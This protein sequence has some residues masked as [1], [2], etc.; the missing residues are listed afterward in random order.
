[1]TLQTVAWAVRSTISTA[2][3]HSPGQLAFNHDMIM[4]TAIKVNWELVKQRK[5]ELAVIA[6]DRENKNCIQHAFGVGD[7]VLIILDKQ[8]RGPKLASPTEGPYKILKTYMNGTIKIQRGNY[9][10]IISVRRLKSFKG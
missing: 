8:E 7:L 5:R 1:M 2:T 9:E 10:E 3:R 6:N 4:Q